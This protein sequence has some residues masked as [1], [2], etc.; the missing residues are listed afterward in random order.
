MHQNSKRKIFSGLMAL[1]MILVMMNASWVSASSDYE[2]PIEAVWETT[3]EVT[4]DDSGEAEESIAEDSEPET[5][6]ITA[7]EVSLI[8]D[9]ESVDEEETSA[10]IAGLMEEPEDMTASFLLLSDEELLPE[11]EV[12]EEET[13]SE[14]AQMLMLSAGEEALTVS[15]YTLYANSSSSRTTYTLEGSYP[16]YAYH[17]WTSSNTRAVGLQNANQPTATAYW[18]TYANTSNITHQVSRDGRNWTTVDIYHLTI[19]L[20]S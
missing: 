11:E 12:L 13:G 3:E 9:G 15:E 6:G 1:V 2:E 7:A 19:I 4:A 10:E 5:D 17:R 8:E 18:L 16:E 14:T 20:E